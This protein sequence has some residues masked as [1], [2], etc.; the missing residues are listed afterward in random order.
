[1][2]SNP[3]KANLIV[4][5]LLISAT[6]MYAQ[7]GIGASYEERNEKPEKGF[8][9]Q[10]EKDFLEAIPI[11]YLRGRVH[12]SQF[13]SE[14]Q[15]SYDGD[16]VIGDLEANDIG[17]AVI[18]GGKLGFISPYA[19][20]GFGIENW[21]YKSSDII[22]VNEK[23]DTG[24]YYGIVGVSVTIIPVIQPYIEYR[25]TN[26]NDMGEAR[27]EIGEGLSRVHVGLTLRF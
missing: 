8:G 20:L 10:L 17:L 24:Y 22:S 11:F 1:M 26:Y 7:W 25:V 23:D 15:L 4:L 2:S 27:K 9:I 18:G 3:V 5:I 21:S 14:A 19:G 16:F 6:P 13:S 12:Y